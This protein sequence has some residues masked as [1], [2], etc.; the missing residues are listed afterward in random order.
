M[1]KS[2]YDKTIKSLSIFHQTVTDLVNKK[3][4]NRIDLAFSLD[5]NKITSE[6]DLLKREFPETYKKYLKHLLNNYELINHI[7]DNLL[8]TSNKND[9]EI[10]FNE[11]EY[12]IDHLSRCLKQIIY[13]LK[14][15]LKAEILTPQQ[16]EG[17]E[18]EKYIIP[19]DPQMNQIFEI[20][21]STIDCDY[22]LFRKSIVTANFHLLNIKR[23]N[24]V[25]DLTYRL[26]N[27]MG[28]EWYGEVCMK[29]NWTKSQCSGQGEKLEGNLMTKELNKILARPG[30]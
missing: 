9:E 10:E 14:G 19:N 5:H 2:I 23:Q 11:N 4:V 28:N 21:K 6:F 15:M 8:K 18:L 22:L 1:S 20:C 30:K 17:I 3:T 7:H 25:K 13:Y 26:S 24:F 27:I 16:N 12:H 29:M